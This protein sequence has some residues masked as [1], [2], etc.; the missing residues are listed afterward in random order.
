[1]RS[2]DFN[3][4]SYGNQTTDFSVTG[5][6]LNGSR[7]TAKSL[8]KFFKNNSLDLY[9]KVF[10]E[11]YENSDKRTI[12]DFDGYRLKTTYEYYPNDVIRSIRQEEVLPDGRKILRLDLDADGVWDVVLGP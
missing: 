9:Q 2:I 6:F 8:N 10:I 7:K 4:D 3:N 1:V 11:F 12:L 5:R